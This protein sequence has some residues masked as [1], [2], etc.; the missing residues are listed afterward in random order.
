MYNSYQN[1]HVA[2]YEML[3]PMDYMVSLPRLCPLDPPCGSRVDCRRC[4]FISKGVSGRTREVQSLPHCPNQ[5]SGVTRPSAVFVRF[6]CPYAL[7]PAA[8][9]GVTHVVP[10]SKLPFRAATQ[11]V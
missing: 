3:S 6:P 7:K 5:L 9:G 10:D 1:I 4:S 2:E 11:N 8:L